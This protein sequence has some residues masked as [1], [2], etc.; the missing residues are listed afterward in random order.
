MSG[1]PNIVANLDRIKV[2][3]LSY[4]ILS[5]PF[6]LLDG[7]ND[8]SKRGIEDT[9]EHKDSLVLLPIGASLTGVESEGS[10]DTQ[11]CCLR[12]KL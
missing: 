3:I 1:Y 6:A 5:Y 8:E 10:G 4:P 9:L 2:I 11:V 7:T 12:R